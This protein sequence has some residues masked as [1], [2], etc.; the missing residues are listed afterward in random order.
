MS[1][2]TSVAVA[3]G[4]A[5]M[6][7]ACFVDTAAPPTRVPLSFAASI[8]AAAWP[9]GGFLNTLPQLGSASGWVR[10]RHARARSIDARI[11]SPAPGRSASVAA[12]T[13]AS[14]GK[15]DLRYEKAAASAETDT[16]R[17]SR[18]W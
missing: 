14:A 8:M 13:I 1:A 6:K 15:A 4:P 9:P 10:L 2:R 11:A 17:P 5:T 7:L 3:S 12:V 16:A 18:S